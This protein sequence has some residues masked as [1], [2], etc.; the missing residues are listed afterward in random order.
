MDT[1]IEQFYNKIFSDL[2]IDSG[3]A[4]ELNKLMSALNPPPDKLTKL[5]ASAFKVASNYISDDNEKNTQLL[6][7]INSVVQVVEQIYMEPINDVAS[8]A[9]LDEEALCVLYK[10][11]MD[12]STVDSEESKE[13]HTYFKETNPLDTESLVMARTLAFKVGTEQLTDDKE[14]NIQVLRCI[15]VIVHALEMTCYEPK[16][17]QLQLDE[18]VDLNMNLSAA[19]QHLWDI[20][21]NRLTP[22]DDFV[23]N[24]QTGKKPFWKEDA[25]RDPL[26]TS[27]DKA[28]R[29]RPTYAAFLALLNN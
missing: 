20:V 13:L 16:P 26:F 7:T 4:A 6:R 24:V 27:V 28:V 17:F 9:S 18:S 14:A 25:A 29:K 22:G 11:I 12:G 15:N 3:E 5:R 19:V 8:A 21:V 23:L 2:T 1:Q 10:D